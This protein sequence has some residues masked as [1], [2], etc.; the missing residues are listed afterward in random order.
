MAIISFLSSLSSLPP[1][2]GHPSNAVGHFVM[3][4]VLGAL[5]L[6]ASAGG[7]WSGVTRRALLVAVIGTTLFGV[8]DEAHQAFVPIRT[9]E[10]GDV[11]VD[12][13]GAATAVG[14]VW[15]WGIIRRSRAD[16]ANRPGGASAP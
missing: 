7:G 13:L 1:V 8:A 9:P 12:G 5:W 15:A 10:L 2:P 4:G 16:A 6:R 11:V 3:F 14:L